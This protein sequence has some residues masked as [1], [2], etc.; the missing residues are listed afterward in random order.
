MGLP[1]CKKVVT[2][3]LITKDRRAVVVEPEP[4]RVEY[5][6]LTE[7]EA[8]EARECLDWFIRHLYEGFVEWLSARP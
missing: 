7:K 4:C 2:Y 6:P 8:K 1:L 3:K 5:V